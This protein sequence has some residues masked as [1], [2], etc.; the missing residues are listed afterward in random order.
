MTFKQK[1]SG[2]QK[3]TRLKS[4]PKVTNKMFRCE[5]K[6]RAE[7]DCSIG[8]FNLEEKSFSKEEFKEV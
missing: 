8:R 4:D 7:K 1:V 6:N 2:L 3:K 5:R